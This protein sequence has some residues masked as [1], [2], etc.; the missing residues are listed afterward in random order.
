M[1]ASL[2]L[3]FTSYDLFTAPKWI[4]LDN[5]K[6]MFTGDEKYWQSLKVTFTYVLAG[7]PLRLGFAL[8]IAVILNNAAKG[9]AIYRTLFYLPSIIGGSVAVAIMWR[10]ILAMTGSSMRCCFLSGL[11]KNSLVP[12]SDKCAVDIDS[13]VRLAV[14]VVNADF[15]GRAEKHSV[16]VFGSGKC[17]WG[18]S[19]AAFLQDH[20]SDSYTDYFL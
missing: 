17:G 16:F 8:F 14:R 9:T 18:K 6:E 15:S 5:F 11:I 10:N 19:G 12:E 4:G 20:A 1:G 13:A 3:S 7:V 2:F